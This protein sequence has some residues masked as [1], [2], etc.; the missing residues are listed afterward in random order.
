MNRTEILEGGTV[1]EAHDTCLAVEVEGVE[2][3]VGTRLK[4]RGCTCCGD[5]AELDVSYNLSEEKS[6]EKHGEV[7]PLNL[8]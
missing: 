3:F 4:R 6:V 1:V 8:D 2:V 5:T 7:D